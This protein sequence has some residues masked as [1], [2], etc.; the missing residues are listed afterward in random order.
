MVDFGRHDLFGCQEAQAFSWAGVQRGG[1]LGEVALGQSGQVHALGQILPQ[2]A[3]GVLVGR[4]LPGAVGVGEV[5]P[6][7]QPLGQLLVAGHFLALVVGQGFAQARRQGAQA[8][9]KACQDRLGVGAI[10]F[11]QQDEAALALDQGTNSA[12]VAG[13]LDEVAIPVAGHLAALDLERSVMDGDHVAQPSAPVL[14]AA[15]GQALLVGLAQGADQELAQL[16]AG[17]S[18]D[19][20]ID[21]LVGDPLG[22]LLGVHLLESARDLLGGPPPLKLGLDRS[23]QHRPGGELTRPAPTPPSGLLAGPGGVVARAAVAA[24]LPADGARRAVQ[25]PGQGTAA[26]PEVQARLD[27]V[28]LLDRQL[29]EPV[30]HV[31]TL[32]P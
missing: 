17:L 31:L 10:D 4:A 13:A 5:D 1:D 6:Q 21:G 30:A 16:A 24:D 25:T 7:V 26:Q 27:V 3:V 12:G 28:A 9:R 20:G 19:V 29:F 14:A 23:L 2:Q 18:V 11:G 15:A 22:R 8:P 32:P